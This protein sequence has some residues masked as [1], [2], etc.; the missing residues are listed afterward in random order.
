[1]RLKLNKGKP[2]KPNPEGYFP[3]NPRSS[4]SSVDKTLYRKNQ[5]S[6]KNRKKPQIDNEK[7]A[8]KKGIET[9]YQEKE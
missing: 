5:L 2:G 8:I 9:Y 6:K 1:M 7:D 4:K 3:P